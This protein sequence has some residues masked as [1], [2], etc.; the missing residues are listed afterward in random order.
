MYTAGRSCFVTTAN[1]QMDA[2]PAAFVSG[3]VVALAFL[4][5]AAYLWY[6]YIGWKPFAYREGEVVTFSAGKT[7]SAGSIRFRGATFTVTAP[8]GTSRS[9]DVTAILNG[10]A[11]AY[12]G[13]AGAATSSFSLGGKVCIKKNAKGLCTQTGRPRPLN[14]FT[15]TIAGFND[16]KTVP[17]KADAAEWTGAARLTGEARLV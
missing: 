4:L 5:V 14:P 12:S 8:D 17:T 2:E 3:L 6:N 7:E 13:G 11:L 15:F 1:Q 9:K 10:M 16:R